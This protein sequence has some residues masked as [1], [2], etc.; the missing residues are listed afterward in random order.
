[1]ARSRR[2]NPIHKIQIIRSIGN[3]AGFGADAA[4]EEIIA[5]VYAQ[6]EDRG[7]LEIG[8]EGVQYFKARTR[9]KVKSDVTLKR[10]QRLQDLI[11][12]FG[13]A[14]FGKEP[15]GST[16]EELHRTYGAKAQTDDLVYDF[17]RKKRYRTVAIIQSPDDKF[18]TLN[19]EEV[20]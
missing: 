13:S 4:T 12:S 15:F 19:C 11:A 2:F 10:N 1:M 5:T 7:G 18:F 14:A 8:A 20:K 6:R 17:G 3:P 16:G 9:Y